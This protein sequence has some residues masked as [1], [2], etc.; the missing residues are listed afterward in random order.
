MDS[1]IQHNV[2]L[3]DYCSLNAGGN[4]AHF[5]Q[6]SN[7]EQLTAACD[8]T[9]ELGL[10]V[11]VLGHGTNSLISDAG[12]P[13]TVLVMRNDESPEA[14]DDLIIANAGLPWDRL[15][16][17]CIAKGLWGVEFMSA[18]PGSVGAAVVINIAAYGQNVSEVLAW[19]DV[20]N[21]HTGELSRL[22]VD[23]LGYS[24]K[25]SVL[26][27]PDSPWVVTR[28]AFKLGAGPTKEL[29]YAQAL[30]IAAELDLEPNTL[31]NRRTIVL[32]G[33]HR[34]GA[35]Y[36][37]TDPQ[38]EH[39]AGSFFK[40]PLVTAEQAEELAGYEET[41]ITREQLLAQNRIHGGEAR[42]ISPAMVLLA[43]GFKRGQTW[44][45]V[46]LHPQHV[47]KIENTG[48]AQAQQI[49]DV[50]QEIMS[51]VKAKLGIELEPEVRF[52]GEFK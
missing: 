43:A 30:K 28:A 37:E 8:W 48:G 19:A 10:P 45:P 26:L 14:D 29:E 41:N 38:R 44:G 5:A 50:A 3:A 21:L 47:L 23:D 15:V 11:Y 6:I 39:T 1:L 49:Y 35:L 16:Q 24:Y 46:R 2:S 51:T 40:S 4:A 36:D 17:F 27:K 32:E 12:L 20:Y 42:R 22:M 33:R 18:I 31:A 7:T 13:G 25:Q 9:R 52:L 34:I